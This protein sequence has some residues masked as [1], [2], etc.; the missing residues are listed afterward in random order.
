ML[1]QQPLPAIDMMN[2]YTVI[3]CFLLELSQLG[4][5]PSDRATLTGEKQDREGFR[6][7]VVL[8]QGSQDVEEDL[9]T[10]RE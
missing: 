6:K 7:G 2:A 5:E 10:V 3:R 8:V 9:G 1:H 4:L